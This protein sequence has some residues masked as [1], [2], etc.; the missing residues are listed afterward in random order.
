MKRSPR[1]AQ[2]RFQHGVDFGA[3]QKIGKADDTSANPRRPVDAARAH[4]GDAVDELGFAERREFRIAVR[5]IHGVALQ[6]H[7]GADVVTACVD[8][9]LDLVEQIAR[10]AIP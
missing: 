9:A 10:A 6:V 3:E 1:G 4:R 5:A 2:V 7:R 8:V